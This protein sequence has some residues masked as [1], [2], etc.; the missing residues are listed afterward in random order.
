MEAMR[1]SETSVPT[2]ATQRN[3]PGDGILPFTNMEFADKYF[4]N[5]F[6]TGN[7]LAS[8]GYKTYL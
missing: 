1:S 7:S 6:C 8:L 3:I 4:T 5:E 2:R